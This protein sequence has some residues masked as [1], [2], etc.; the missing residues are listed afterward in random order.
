MKLVTQNLPQ[1]FLM[2]L[3]GKFCLVWSHSRMAADYELLDSS[4]VVLDVAVIVSGTKY[5]AVIIPLIILI[6]YIVQFFYLRTSR[7]MRHLDIEAK[8]PLYTQLNELA[9]GLDYIR[10]FGWQTRRLRRCLRLLDQSQKP[11]YY[12]SAIQRW[13]ELVLDLICAGLAIT[14]VAVAVYGENNTSQA[15]L[16]LSLLTLISFTMVTNNAIQK[17]ASLETSIGALARLREFIQSTPV[18]RHADAPQPRP[19]NWPEEG[20]IVFHNVTASYEYVFQSYL[21]FHT[22]STFAH[23]LQRT[24]RAAGAQ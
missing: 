22:R 13:L 19:E 12:M 24:W 11:Y 7:Q 8:A 2:V 16:G 6:T 4:F 5:S 21:C 17:W 1:A 9:N 10:A 3:Y 14:I 18:E 23:I 15:A 20:R